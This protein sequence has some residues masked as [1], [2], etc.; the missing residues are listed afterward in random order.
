[1]NIVSK[2]A[3]SITARKPLAP[4][5]LSRAIF[6]ISFIA[7]FSNSSSILSIDKSSLY[8]LINAFF[9]SSKILIREFSFKLS[10]VTIIGILPT[11]SGIKP[12]LSKSSGLKFLII[13]EKSSSF[14]V[15]TSAPNPIDFFSSLAFKIESI[16]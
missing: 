14:S 13:S 16:P 4:V 3:L 10:K 8:C 2:R 11:N 5:F 15:L 7:S 9:G 6:A 1:M 12:Y